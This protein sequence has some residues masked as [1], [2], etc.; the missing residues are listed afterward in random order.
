M[1]DTKSGIVTRSTEGVVWDMGPTRSTIFKLLC[2]ESN[3]SIPHSIARSKRATQPEL[4]RARFAGGSA[5]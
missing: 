3:G 2:D 5:A 4:N 1:A